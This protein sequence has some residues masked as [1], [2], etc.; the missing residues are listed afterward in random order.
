MAMRPTG[1]SVAGATDEVGGSMG[2]GSGC[3][4]ADAG[5]RPGRLG[6]MGARLSYGYGDC[7]SSAAGASHSL[8]SEAKGGGCVRAASHAALVTGP[9]AAPLAMLPSPPSVTGASLAP[10]P[11]S[12]WAARMIA[13]AK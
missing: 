1:R 3:R 13:A 11:G 2:A 8:R 10:A 12:A 6:C 9:S 5:V 7:L 4:L